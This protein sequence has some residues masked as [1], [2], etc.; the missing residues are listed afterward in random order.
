MFEYYTAIFFI[1]VATLIIL[2]LLVKE[3]G[4]LTAEQKR[5]FRL[6]YLIISLAALMEWL[7]LLLDGAPLCTRYLHIIIKC[8]GY[9]LNFSIA[10]F[11]A[12]QINEK[13]WVKKHLRNFMCIAVVILIISLPF[14]AIF[15]VDGNNI[16]HHGKYYYVYSVIYVIMWFLLLIG[17]LHFGRKYERHNIISMICISLLVLVCTIIQQFINIKGIRTCFLSVSIASV[18][19]FIHYEEFYQQKMDE[20]RKKKTIL[21]EKD[22]LTGLYSRYAYNKQ[23]NK[24]KS[25]PM[26]EK[27][28]VLL[29]DINGLKK[30][31]D[32]KGHEMGDALIYA[33]GASLKE[34]VANQGQIFRTGGDEFVILLDLSHYS[35]EQFNKQKQESL[36]KYQKDLQGLYNNEIHL[37]MGVAMVKDYPTYTL[38][39]LVEIADKHMYEDKA[40]FYRENH[41]DRR[42]N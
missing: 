18:L 7:G 38:E 36:K 4:R 2:A 3:N 29:F 12:I 21:L 1:S 34:A 37:A 32:T 16:Y 39:Q 20:E 31:N 24:Y 9:I 26:P 6:T 17:F 42:R 28:C 11:F 5:S 23:L 8:A 30:V 19:L 27:M 33:T 10:S 14:K 35:L 15:Y 40:R 13:G 25:E 22:V 41:I